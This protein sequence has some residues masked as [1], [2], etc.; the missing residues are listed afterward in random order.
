MPI[1]PKVSGQLNVT[2]F[3]EFFLPVSVDDLCWLASYQRCENVLS[4][5]VKL[6]YSSATYL[7]LRE[8]VYDTFVPR[9]RPKNSSFRLPYQRHSSSAD[10]A[11]ELFKGSN[12]SASLLVC[13]RK[14][15]FGWGCRFFVSDIIIEVVLGS[16]W[17]MLSGLWPNR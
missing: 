5:W 7:T 8:P 6:S 10:C 17:L 1:G 13:T 12:K 11:R 15:F 4:T 16:F 2:G 9:F 14:K 3:V